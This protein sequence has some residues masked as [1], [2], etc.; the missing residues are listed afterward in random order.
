[1]PTLASA[2]VK[3]P[4]RLLYGPGPSMVEPRALE[5]MSQPALGIRDPYLLGLIDEIRAGLRTAFGTSNPI[6]FPVPA[7]G[8][9]AMETAVS[10]FVPAGSKFAV[11]AAGHFADRITSMAKR[12]GAN[13]VRCEQPWGSVFSAETAEEF[14]GREQPDVVAFVQAET[15][16]GAYQS[17]H[18]IAQAAKKAGALVIADTV[19]SLAAMPVEL[20]AVGVDVAFSCGQKGL[21]CPAGLSPVSISPRAWEWLSTRPVESG[22][23]YFDLRLLAKYYDPPHVYHHTPAPP[24]FY[25]MYEALASIQEE[26]IANRFARHQAAH[27]QLMAGLDRLGFTPVVERPEDRI[28][29]V[30]AVYPPA[31]VVEADLRQ[32]L[33]DRYNIE[34]ASGLGAFAGKILRIGT[35]GPLATEEHVAFL[36]EAIEACL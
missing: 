27:K 17:G 13:V 28:W 2:R 16:T 12:F 24:L 15:S 29:H 4:Q 7:S 36:L 23:W 32:R 22:S 18:A 20:D 14:I 1:M 34:I 9:G 31:G 11:F 25:A 10:N 8:S 3:A 30:T 6:T 19:T 21:S 26:G 35:M 5:A 33:V